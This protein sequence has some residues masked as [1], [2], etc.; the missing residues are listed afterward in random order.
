LPLF[1]IARLRNRKVFYRYNENYFEVPNVYLKIFFD[2]ALR[3]VWLIPIV[4]FCLGW[5]YTGN[6]YLEIFLG[7][8]IGYWTGW[9]WVN[10][11]MI[12]GFRFNLSV[13]GDI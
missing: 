11:T 9:L 1:I 10:G 2:L 8:S 12:F 3:A 7:L 4:C 5:I 13:K 6:Y